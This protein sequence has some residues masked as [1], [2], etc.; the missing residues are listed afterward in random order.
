MR[1]HRGVTILVLGLL[2]LTICGFFGP[3]AWVM[4]TRDLEEMQAGSLDPEGRG[5]TRAGQ[6]LGMVGT[7]FAVVQVGLV[8]VFLFAAPDV[9][10]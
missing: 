10:Q 6:V 5:L 8:V 9:A 3:V 1:P 2:S 7:A 4:G